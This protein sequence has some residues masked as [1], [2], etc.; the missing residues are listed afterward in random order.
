MPSSAAGLDWLETQGLDADLELVHAHLKRELY[1][2]TLD[3]LAREYGVSDG[4]VAHGSPLIRRNVG[5]VL[6]VR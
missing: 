1:G 3:D 4:G 5:Q 6:G 2:P